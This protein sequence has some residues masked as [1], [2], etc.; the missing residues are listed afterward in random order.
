MTEVAPL[1]AKAPCRET[2]LVVPGISCAG[3]IAKIE[4]DLVKEPA[5]V[6][7]RVR[8]SGKTV[9]VTHDPARDA[10]WLVERL[11]DLGFDAQ[12]LAAAE[13]DKGRDPEL[14]ALVRAMAVAGFASMNV[15]LLSVSIWSG[16][17]D[18][19][20]GLFHWLSA[21][22]AIPAIAYAGRPFFG[23]A[24]AA[25]AARRTNMDVPISVGLVLVTAM[26]LYETAIGGP[27]AW[28]DGALML[29]FF[30]LAGRVMDRMM[31]RRAEEGVRSL[32]RQRAP[33]AHVVAPDGSTAWRETAD[34][35][36][37][38]VMLV[39]AGDRFAA[40]GTVVEGS[41][42]IDSSLLTGESVP[43]R[44]GPG[45]KVA[46]GTLN[47]TAP[48]RVR[49]SRVGNSDTVAELTALM[50][51][52]S[53]SD[54]RYVRLAD[55]AARIYTPAVHALAVAAF[56]GWMMA[57]AGW[58]QALLVAIA[59]LI[60]T[61]P[62]ALGLAVPAAQVVACGRLMKQG[63]LVKDGSALERIADID[64]VY[65]DK[66]GTL[67]RGEPV[68][69]GLEMLSDE[70][71]SILLALV[72]T[73]RHPLSRATAARLTAEGTAPAE[74]ENIGEEPGLGLSGTYAGRRV[75]YDRPQQRV[76]TLAACYSRDGQPDR[77]IGFRDS[78]RPGAG[79]VVQDL[80]RKGFETK[81]L[82]GDRQ[83][84]VTAV[85]ASVG[86]AAEAR[87]T[88]SAKMRAIAE[89][90]SAGRRVLMVGDGL[91]DAPALAVA[92]ASM[93]PGTASDASQQAADIVFLGSALS[94]VS[95]VI[96]ASRRTMTIVRQNVG[97]SIGY[98]LLAVPL[99]MAGLVTPLVAAI[100]MS[101]SSVAVVANSLRLARG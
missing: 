37:G 44:T 30:L 17:G 20:R 101:V 16:A 76:A 57:G 36:P 69:S 52:A 66:T 14:T 73:S 29:L 23:S 85:A 12:P 80:R 24:L 83:E 43:E 68:P 92:T 50:E 34:L 58:H 18:A 25:L 99:A 88:P 97:L 56:A 35:A 27:H 65:F 93:A 13:A 54:S 26:S 48:V 33:G 60:I 28:F 62:C 45:A 8:F 51:A 11:K 55:R 7:A 10:A 3:C 31:R 91:N 89:A 1:A 39:A 40:D 6:A 86:L 46:A 2:R 71:R 77:L 32:L 38:M 19:T 79:E 90:E 84:V 61:C 22:I 72:Q 42:E 59:V 95:E 21:L 5:I 98:N 49:I 87:L 75:S 4:R 67:T 94:P 78:V 100:A 53:Q 64:T 47:L 41:S 63:I 74:V 15:M 81:M 96:D 70:D 9:T 82:S